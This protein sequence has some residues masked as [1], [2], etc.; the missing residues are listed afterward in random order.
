MRLIPK[1]YN[2]GGVRLEQP[3]KAV[4][5]G[6]LG[7]WEENLPEKL[8]ILV[9][10][11][12]MRHTDVLKK[13]NADILGHFTTCNTDHHTLVILNPN[14]GDPERKKL[15]EA[16]VIL[17]QISFQVN[18][19]KE[20]NDAHAF[21]LENDIRISRIGRDLPGSNWAVYAFDPDGHRVELFYGMEQI[22]WSGNSKPEAMYERLPYVTFT[23]PQ[24]A[25]AQEVQQAKER[26]IDLCSGFSCHSSQPHVYDVGGVLLQQPF[27][28]SKVGP[29][30]IFVA[31]M[32]K[33]EHFYIKIIGL[34]K[35]EEVEYRGHK[36]V[37]LS[38]GQEHHCVALIPIALRNMLGFKENTTL[39][40]IGLQVQTY[41]QLRQAGSFLIEKG[42]RPVHVPQELQP[43]IQYALHFALD[44]VNLLQIYFEMDGFHKKQS[45]NP[46][47]FLPF[48]QWPDCIEAGEESYTTQTRLGPMG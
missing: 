31:D 5:L 9:D 7:L 29:V 42:L 27:K 34:K 41:E 19:L 48:E 33:S 43:G 25:E 23:L 16:G 40:S 10:V 20:V 11:L 39:L 8:K 15:Y 17:N 36:C 35:T 47:A 26:N 18:S 22:G 30:R 45:E 1:K 28:V 2:V 14:S 12:G 46:Y 6:H 32:E 4:R 37:Y 24:K 21:F 3:F 13:S 44:E 38:T